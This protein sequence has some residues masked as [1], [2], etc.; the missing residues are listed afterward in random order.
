MENK[1]IDISIIIPFFNG[2]KLIKNLID[3]IRGQ[4][5]SG[6]LEII[7]LVTLSQDKTLE[8]AEKYC[9]KTIYIEKFNHG[10]T[11]H[12]GALRAQGKIFVFITQDILP[13]DKNWLINLI[14]PLGKNS[15]VAS[16]SKQIAYPDALP[17]EKYIREFNYPDSE[18]VC[19][20]EN[21]TINGRKNL[22]YSDSSSA[23]LKEEYFK[24]KGYDIEVD[25]N[26]DVIF[27][28]KILK[29]GKRYRYTPESKVYHSHNSTL[30]ELYRRYRSIGKFEYEYGEIFKGYESQGEGI[31]MVLN[32]VKKII[33][34]HSLIQLLILP[35]NIGSRYLGYHAGKREGKNNVRVFTDI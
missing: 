27:A 9:D 4:N 6:N 34:D 32:I 33:A 12:E 21:R 29:S 16:F 11:R 31:K 14:S 22:F 1:E 35:F 17:L 18:R 5:Y 3:N 10:K 13:C 26:E 23:C 19:S 24:L 28:Y 15:V 20:K 25:T 7:G 2:E 8:T 30:G